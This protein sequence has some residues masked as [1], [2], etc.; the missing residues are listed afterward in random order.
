MANAN[1]TSPAHGTD[2]FGFHW[3]CSCNK[4]DPRRKAVY[5]L[6]DSFSQIPSRWIE[7]LSEHR[8]EWLS[9][10]MWGTFFVPKEGADVRNIEKLMKPIESD[11]ED[12]ESLRDAGWQ[13]V[14]ETGI[15]AVW[16]D[17]ELLLG[18]HGAG[19]DFYSQ[20]WSKLY[21]SL[22][23]RWYEPTQLQ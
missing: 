9:L 1:N 22:G 4:C 5:R 23:Y 11:N 15:Y 19:Y 7:E 13:E 8:D 12:H 3:N 17:D 16:F 2:I 18:I 21:D 14:A 20:H 6:V 10:P